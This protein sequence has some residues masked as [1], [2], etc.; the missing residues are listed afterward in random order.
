MATEWDGIAATEIRDSAGEILDL[1]GA[2]ISELEAGRGIVNSDH[3]N[4]FGDVIG[5]IVEA[6]KIFG[7]EDCK[8]DRQRYYWNQVKSPY[9]YVKGKLFDTYGEHRAAKAAAAILKYQHVEDAPL[10]MRLSVEGGIVER[11]SN[12]QRLLKRTKIR[13]VAATF[14]PANNTTV[15]EGLN[16]RKSSITQEELNLIN[17]CIPLIKTNFPAFIEQMDINSKLRKR[18]ENICS[19]AKALVA[20]YS[21]ASAPTERTQGSVLM[22]ESI[23]GAKDEKDDHIQCADCGKRQIYMMHQ[24]RCRDCG[25]TFSFDNLLRYIVKGKKK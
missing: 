16:L 6:K 2:D 7:P 24:T 13:A 20:G 19:L 11:G 21:G 17:S 25:K 12:D 23:D 1:K 9:L 4:R 3:S 22:T 14:Q 18:I 5:H 8:D 15:M 10:K